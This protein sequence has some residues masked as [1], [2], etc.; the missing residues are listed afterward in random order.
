M[1]EIRTF[2]LR[3]CASTLAPLGTAISTVPVTSL[4]GPPADT[5]DH[6]V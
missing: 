6:A 2:P 5:E 4:G 1:F 3:P